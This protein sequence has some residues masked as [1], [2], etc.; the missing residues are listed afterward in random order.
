MK[1]IHKAS[2]ELERFDPNKFRQSLQRAGASLETIGNLAYQV[3]NRA[4]LQTTNDIYI[5]V[6]Q[7]LQ[8]KEKPV[9][10]RYN[11]KRA[12]LA[13][14]PTGFPFERFVAHVFQAQGH[15][16]TVG[17]NIPGFCV[18]HEVDVVAHKNDK[19]Y[20]IE[21]KFHNEQQFQCNVKTNLYVQAR[22][23]D[24][25]KQEIK[26]NK[27]QRFDTI[28]LVTN[29]KF[30]DQAVQYGLCVNMRMLSW[31]YPANE[32]LAQLVDRYKLYPITTL[33]SLSMEQKKDLID[34]GFVLCRDANEKRNTLNTLNLPESKKEEIIK[35]SLGICSLTQ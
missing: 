31:S 8:K 15:K 20:L 23:E 14:G 19:H 32:G 18:L 10:G 29:T 30:T 9:A 21:C 24:I 16:T 6:M 13:F 11:L 7:E 34:Q 28:W 2:G 3:E 25:K 4:D 5:F 1:Y 12:L 22:F 17:Q 26:D 33:T 35:E 27:Q